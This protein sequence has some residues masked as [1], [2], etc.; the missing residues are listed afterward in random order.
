[1][2]SPTNRSN[3]TTHRTIMK[4]ITPLSSILITLSLLV[5]CASS[6]QDGGGGGR[7]GGSGGQ[8]DSRQL[9]NSSSKSRDAV[10]PLF[11]EFTSASAEQV[12]MMDEDLNVMTRLVEKA[13]DQ[14]LGEEKPETKLNLPLLLT[15]GGR[16]VRAMYLEGFGA[17]FMIKVNF[18]VVAVAKVESKKPPKKPETEWDQIKSELKEDEQA[19]DDALVTLN[20]SRT[21]YDASQI[22]ALKKILLQSLKH[23]ANIRPLKPDEFVALSVFGSDVGSGVQVYRTTYSTAPSAATTPASPS[24]TKKKAKVPAN[25]GQ[26]DGSEPTGPTIVTR[27]GQSAEL[28]VSDSRTGAILTR[29]VVRGPGK[30][31][32]QGTVLTVR[33]KKSDVDAFARGE[34]NLET[35]Q[36]SAVFNAYLGNGYGI[37]SLNSWAGSA[38]SSSS[39]R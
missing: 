36:K 35:F 9:R 24:S 28:N 26:G 6:A 19:D 16:S 32:P 1:M 12:A 38:R 14:G 17:L 20:P 27:P 3:S 8:G 13:L 39:S 5:G 23:A 2:T 18:P 30:A 34:M 10:P 4:P 11:I 31:G 21:A 25:E 7:G 37:L 33:A 15:S 22:E 29:A